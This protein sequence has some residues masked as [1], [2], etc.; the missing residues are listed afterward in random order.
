MNAIILGGGL[1]G[2]SLAYFLQKKKNIT[3][4]TIVEKEPVLG[5]LCRSFDYDGRKYDIGPH[6]IFSKDTEIVDLML[7]IL[8]DNHAQHRRSNQILY[9]GREIQYPFENDLSKLPAEDLAYCLNSF[10]YN[11]YV[12]YPADNM[13]QFFLKTFGEGIVNCYLRPYNEKIWKFDP[14]YM[15]TQMVSRIPQPPKEDILRSARGETIDGYLHQLYFHYP[16]HNGIQS[17]IDGFSSRFNEKVTTLLG[18]TIVGVEKKNTGYS[19]YSADGG[20]YA[21]DMLFSTI[22]LDNLTNMYKNISPHIADIGA[23][24]KSNHTAIVVVTLNQGMADNFAL[25]IPDKNI[26]FHRLTCLDYFGGDYCGTE[27]ITYLAEIS[28][29]DND[30]VDLMTDEELTARV[31]RGL[32]DI[33]IADSMAHIVAKDVRRIKYTYVIYDIEHKVNTASIR[34]FFANESVILHGRFGQFEY[35][36]MDRVLRESKKLAERL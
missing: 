12:D 1:A 25:F 31:V 35:W 23:R 18:Q 8:G 29:R 6:I 17:L 26:I 28:Y 15:D 11:P 9:K 34:D 4:I 3:Q 33:G 24:L 10:L 14:T 22:P 32:Y 21:A 20:A 19:V 36:N 2:T 27:G 16:K 5:G 30:Q 7:D 13:L